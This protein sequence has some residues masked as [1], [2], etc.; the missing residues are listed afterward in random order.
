MT[1]FLAFAIGCTLGFTV[2]AFVVWG[3]DRVPETVSQKFSCGFPEEWKDFEQRHRLFLERFPNIVAALNTAF[4]RSAT[5]SELID[6]FVF[7][8]G[9]LSCEDFFELGLCWGMAMGLRRLSWYA[10]CMKER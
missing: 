8:Y 6:K 1:D 7:F 5:L 9:R 2:S 10:A 3:R 4:I